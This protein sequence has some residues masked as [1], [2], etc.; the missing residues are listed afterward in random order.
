MNIVSG[1][2]DLPPAENVGLHAVEQFPDHAAPIIDPNIACGFSPCRLAPFAR[3]PPG[4]AE[5]PAGPPRTEPFSLAHRRLLGYIGQM[6]SR[7]RTFFA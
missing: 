7:L 6:A 2:N 3:F 4:R 1:R 5:H